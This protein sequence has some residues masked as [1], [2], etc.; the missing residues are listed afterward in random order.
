[1]AAGTYVLEVRDKGDDEVMAYN[2][3]LTCASLTE[4]EPNNTTATADTIACGV[5][6][7]ATIGV[8]G[9]V[10]YW[11][12]SLASQTNVRITCDPGLDDSTMTLY[13]GSVTALGFSDD[14]GPGLG[15]YLTGD[16]AAGTYYL[17]IHEFGDD[18]TIANYNLSVVC[19]ASEESEPNDSAATANA[20]ACNGDT[21]CSALSVAGDVDYWTFSVVEQTQVTITVDC[22]FS[23]STVSLRDAAD[24]E[25]EFDD[26]DGTDLCSF[27]DRLVPA[28]TYFIRVNEFGDDEALTYNLSLACVTI[29]DVDE[30]EPN[31]DDATANPI[32]CG[33]PLRGI[34]SNG[35]DVDF[36][37]NT[38]IVALS[39]VSVSVT[40]PTSSLDPTLTI[41]DSSLNVVAF[42]DD[43]VGLDSGINILLFPDT[44]YFVVDGLS[45]T[46]PAATYTLSVN[47]SAPNEDPQGCIVAGHSLGGSIDVDGESDTWQYVAGAAGTATETIRFIAKSG[48]V[49]V[50]MVVID[51][52]GALA[53]RDEDDADLTDAQSFFDADVTKTYTIYVSAGFGQTGGYTLSAEFVRPTSNFETENNNNIANTDS[54]NHFDHLTGTISSAADVDFFRFFAGAG[55]VVTIRN[56]TA[57]GNDNTPNPARDLMIELQNGSGTPIATDDDGE[58]DFDSQLVNFVLPASPGF[59]YYIVVRNVSGPGDYDLLFHFDNIPFTMSPNV[60]PKVAV[61]SQVRAAFT[62]TNPSV[63]RQISFTVERVIGGVATPLINRP[64]MNAPAG[65]NKSK[66]NVLLDTVPALAAG[67]VIRYRATATVNGRAVV[68]VFDVVVQ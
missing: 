41:L 62:A 56:L 55:D 17:E 26:D 2:V 67:T 46:G 63:N 25:V 21:K 9:D 64:N 59:V 11:T 54:I 61:G 3:S 38:E 24:L 53:D 19:C 13:D 23:D 40:T 58:E 30:T 45:G 10:D 4:S 68:R 22:G 1:M 28:G 48:L 20:I 16:L 29:P 31:N 18:A 27:I 39:L 44:Y 43:A 36:W 7:P 65:L 42:N 57:T 33:T 8:A 60:G 47:C 35:A 6:I 49:D 12:F 50:N 34:I 37:V 51:N 15:S 5:S 32:S 66:P 14:E 52:T